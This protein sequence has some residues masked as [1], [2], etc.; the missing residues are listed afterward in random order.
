MS[1]GSACGGAGRIEPALGA[2][3]IEGAERVMDEH[4]PSARADQPRDGHAPAMRAQ[5]VAALAAPHAI[6]RPAAVELRT[7]FAEPQ[8]RSIAQRECHRAGLR[9][10]RAAAAP[11]DRPC[12]ATR[13]GQRL[14]R[15]V[16]DEIADVRGIRERWY[17]AA[18]GGAETMPCRSR[19]PSTGTGCSRPPVDA[20]DSEC[21][22][23]KA[24]PSVTTN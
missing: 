16:D 12:A 20:Q 13:N 14:F 23:S 19:A 1:S 15:D 18:A 24:S 7:T 5:L 9:N 21:A 17:R 11:R 6:G 10:R 3:E 22:S 2:G 4:R 8:D